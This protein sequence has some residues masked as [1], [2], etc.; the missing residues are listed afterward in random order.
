MTTTEGKT[1]SP[2]SPVT[3]TFSPTP[4][5]TE[6]TFTVAGAPIDPP[7]DSGAT[8]GA[9]GTANYV[10]GSL[11]SYTVAADDIY[12]KIAH[13]FG[14]DM[15]YLFSLNGARRQGVDLWIGDTINLSAFHIE[16]IGDENGVVYN[17]PPP[18]PIPPQR[19]ADEP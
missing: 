5:A 19:A 17:N 18:V 14:L 10:G 11:L 15:A 13:R 9:N 16:S 4:Y 8:E 7:V 1:P 3:R 2:T 12:E 6:L